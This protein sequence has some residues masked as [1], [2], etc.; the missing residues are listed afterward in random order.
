[1]DLKSAEANVT[2]LASNA[3]KSGLRYIWTWLAVH[4]RT[5]SLIAL[6]LIA[7]AFVAGLAV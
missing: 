2:T 1:M 5:G 7:G 6:G 3:G 4:P